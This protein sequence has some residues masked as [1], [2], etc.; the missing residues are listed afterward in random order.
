MSQPKLKL[1]AMS[2]QEK[3]SWIRLAR[4]ENV[5]PVTFYRLLEAYG[6]ATKAIEAIPELARR[7]GGKRQP[8]VPAVAAAEKEYE[9][10]RN[11]GGDI[12][13]AAED[14]YPL[15]LGAIADAP[16]II[17]VIGNPQIM[18]EPCIAIVGAR[19]AS[20]NGRRFADK[21]AGELGE[22]G[23]VVVS[24]L[25][26]GIDTAAHKGA[27]KTGTIAV[28]AGGIDVIYPEENKDLYKEIAE[29]GLII[30]ES[31]LGQQPFAQSFPRRNRI[32]SGLSKG[33]IVVEA[34]MKS[35]SLITARLAGEQ[36]RDVF[37]VPGSPLDPRA[38]GP[39]ALIRDGATLVRNAADVLETLSDFSGKALREP[40]Q[41]AAPVF[42]I[43]PQE[44]PADAQEIILSHLSY[45]PAGVDE[46]IRTCQLTI[47]VVQTALLELE[48]AG[49]VQRHAGNRVSLRGED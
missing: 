42:K 34:T 39:N 1:M 40:A 32:V 43:A 22:N 49:R 33:V 6:T 47:S 45:N 25:A 9:S 13:T 26:R 35:G 20:M 44:V 12:I 8:K 21:L 38:S 30:A 16:P 3:I 41:E 14:E 19:N 7:G 24:G 36:G 29:R 15:A 11:L 18:H 31:P 2:D 5:G 17:S 48:L 10:V 27:L 28:V 37:A 4:A 46:L 23:R